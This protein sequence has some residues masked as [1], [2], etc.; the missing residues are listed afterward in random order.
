MPPELLVDPSTL[1]FDNLL[2]DRDAIYSVNPHRFE[3]QLLDGIL[4]V[5]RERGLIIGYRDAREDEFWVRG[6]IPGRPIFPGVLMIETAA[7]LISYYVMSEN[8]GKG[9]MGFGGVD[10]VKF[11]GTVVPGQRLIVVGKLIEYRSRRCI[12]ATQG[13]VNGQL[14]YEGVITGMWI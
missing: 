4:G 11:R 14:V 8:P 3:F 7:Q 5:D 12:G 13:I 6:H 9:F 2:A 1:N 10:S